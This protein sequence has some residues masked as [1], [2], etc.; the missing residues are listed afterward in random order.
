MRHLQYRKVKKKV[1]EDSL[2]CDCKW[3]WIQIRLIELQEQCMNE[4]AALLDGVGLSA[5][6]SAMFELPKRNHGELL[7]RMKLQYLRKTGKKWMEPVNT[8]DKAG[9]IFDSG[10]P[11]DGIDDLLDAGFDLF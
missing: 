4:V 8:S 1:D 3:E 10:A 5:A 11:E 7:E 9:A 2:D 6:E